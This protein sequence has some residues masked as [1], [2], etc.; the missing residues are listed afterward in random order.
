[1]NLGKG[2]KEKV[3]CSVMKGKRMESKRISMSSGTNEL[4]FPSDLSLGDEA[5][6]NHSQI[7][8]SLCIDVSSI[9]F[10]LTSSYHRVFWG[11]PYAGCHPELQTLLG[12]AGTKFSSRK[13]T[14]G[15]LPGNQQEEMIF[16]P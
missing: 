15:Q 13:P 3:I 8:C 6:Q 16:C 12:G 5:L 7:F 1:M 14:S 10:L 2:N 4:W 9:S 11:T